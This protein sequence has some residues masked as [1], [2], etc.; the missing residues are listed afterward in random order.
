MQ[1]FIRLNIIII[2]QK[3]NSYYM[4]ILEVAPFVTILYE[5]EP[6]F[7]YTETK[8]LIHATLEVAPFFLQF[9]I[10]LNLIISVE[11]FKC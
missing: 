6:Y 8:L 3:F 11:K 10:R 5:F 7:K 9:C 4:L 1:L 2:I